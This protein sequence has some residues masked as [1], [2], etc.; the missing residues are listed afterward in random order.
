MGVK[1]CCYPILSLMKVV[2]STNK[3]VILYLYAVMVAVLIVLNI[4][5]TVVLQ[6][7]LLDLFHLVTNSL[8]TLR[9]SFLWCCITERAQRYLSVIWSGK[10]QSRSMPTQQTPSEIPVEHLYNHPVTLQRLMAHKAFLWSPGVAWYHGRRNMYLTF[11]KQLAI[12]WT[13]IC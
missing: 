7:T 2:R 10:S 8:V 1:G 3:D 9:A 12:N 11:R 5:L 6:L 13:I 4:V